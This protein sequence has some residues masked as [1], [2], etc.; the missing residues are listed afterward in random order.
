[1]VFFHNSYQAIKWFYTL[2]VFIYSAMNYFS[3]KHASYAG[4]IIHSMCSTLS[5]S[6]PICLWNKQPFLRFQSIGL[7]YFI[8]FSDMTNCHF[9]FLNLRSVLYFDFLSYELC[10]SA[11]SFYSSNISFHSVLSTQASLSLFLKYCV[12]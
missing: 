1:M 3:D 9:N 12:I 8:S 4:I 6:E 11:P 10:F 2:L 7:H 5:P